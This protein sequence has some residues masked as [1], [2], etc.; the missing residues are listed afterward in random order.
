MKRP[1]KVEEITLD[2]VDVLIN[3]GKW[4][5]ALRVVR[6]NTFELKYMKQQRY[7]FL[8]ALAELL[9]GKASMLSYCQRRANTCPDYV[10]WIEGDFLR[11]QTFFLIRAHRLT[12]AAACLDKAKPYHTSADRLAVLT[13]CFGVLAYATGDYED[14]LEL[15]ESADQLWRD[16]KVRSEP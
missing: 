1:I 5:R 13:M 12:E 10:E 8:R 6:T 2:D 4:R 15:F 16:L 9:V 11:D 14:A 3:T 7:W